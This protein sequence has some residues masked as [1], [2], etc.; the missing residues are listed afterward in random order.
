[1]STDF[2]PLGDLPNTVFRESFFSAFSEQYPNH[3]T[4]H[5]GRTLLSAPIDA[6]RLGTGRRAVVYVGAHHGSEWVSANV[7]FA[8]ILRVAEAA[9]RRE[10]MFGVDVSF[11]L[12]NVSVFVVP[13][14]N[15]DGCDLAMTG[16]PTPPIENRQRRMAGE[17]GFRHWQANARGVDLNHNYD[18][19]FAEYKAVEREQDIFPGPTKYS[20]EYPESEPETAAL[21]SF[22]RILAPNAVVSLHTQGEE[23]YFMPRNSPTAE[24]IAHR[25]NRFLAYRIAVPDGT[26]AYGGLCDYSGE[27]LGIPSFTLELGRGENPLPQDI[28]PSLLHRVLPALIRFPTFL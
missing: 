18:Y 16:I 24:R 15:A 9:K 1:M 20:G 28:F 2:P 4:V 13:M 3:P 7:L 6:V 8:F 17:D 26:A 11:L 21:A 12:S 10:R 25:L 19:R 5:I 27:T 23:I 22:I 14:L